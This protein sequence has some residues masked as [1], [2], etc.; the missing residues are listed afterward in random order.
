LVGSF[1]WLL[2]RW[3]GMLASFLG[4][5]PGIALYA[6]L[7]GASAGVVRAAIMGGLSV[8]AI[9][10]RTLLRTDRNGWI[11]LSTDSHQV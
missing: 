6:A 4:F 11:E 2:G 8:F 10:G 9:Q 1:G 3:R 5:A 7:A